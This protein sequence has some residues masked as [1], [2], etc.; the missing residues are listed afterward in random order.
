MAQFYSQ[1]GGLQ[2]VETATDSLQSVLISAQLAV[3][4]QKAYPLHH[5]AVVGNNDPGVA[6]RAQVLGGIEAETAD[7]AESAGSL[8]LVFRSM[9]LSCVLDDR[10]LRIAGHPREVLHG[11][12][13]SVEVDGD[14]GLGFL[15]EAGGDGPRVEVHGFLVDVGEDRPRAISGYGLG[16]GDE[17]ERRRDHL[18]ARSDPEGLQ[19]EK[20]GVAAIRHAT[21]RRNPT[22]GGELGLEQLASLAPNEGPLSEYLLDGGV[23]L[24][25]QVLILCSQVDDRDHPSSPARVSGNSS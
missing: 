2:I 7:V 18:V 23:H 5:G 4:G 15:G 22:E 9:S 1:D 20:Q 10:D 19:G 12:R 16:G 17:A 14:D 8:T 21:G 24:P 3:V 25:L 11:S 13:M 6:R